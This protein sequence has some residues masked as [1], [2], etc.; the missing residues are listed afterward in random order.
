MTLDVTPEEL[1]LRNAPKLEPEF[2]SL[3]CPYCGEKLRGHA[4][5]TSLPCSRCGLTVQYSGKQVKY[6]TD[7]EMMAFSWEQLCRIML[8]DDQNATYIRRGVVAL[9]KQKSAETLYRCAKEL[10]E[11]KKT[12]LALELL[13]E[14]AGDAHKGAGFPRRAALVMLYNHYFS[15]NLTNKD[16]MISYCEKLYAEFGEQDVLDTLRTLLTRQ[17]EEREQEAS[18][19]SKL[20]AD[21]KSAEEKK[22]QE[23][24]R[25]REEMAHREKA[26]FKLNLNNDELLRAYGYTP[27]TPDVNDEIDAIQSALDASGWSSD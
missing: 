12:A 15:E 21:R 27:L 18:R 16:K 7:Q 4:G 14:L 11:R 26:D 13:E 8:S 24:Q 25:I 9:K 23:Q 5:M 6:P 20:E 19:K 17:E 22:R 2:V 10:Y 3:T 1:G